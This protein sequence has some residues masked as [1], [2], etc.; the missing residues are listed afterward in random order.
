MN[1]ISLCSDS[2]YTKLN[3]YCAPLCLYR[4]SLDLIEGYRRYHGH[5]MKAHESVIPSLHRDTARQEP[6]G[7]FGNRVISAAA[8]LLLVRPVYGRS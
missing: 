2:C 6:T 5:P 3:F 7:R 1:T 4:D 8:V